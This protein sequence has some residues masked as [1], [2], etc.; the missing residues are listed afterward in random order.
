GNLIRSAA[1]GLKQTLLNSGLLAES[2]TATDFPDACREYIS[3]YGELKFSSCYGGP[4]GFFFVEHQCPCEAYACVALAV[5]GE[6]SSVDLKTG[7]TSVDD[8]VALQEIGK[9]LHPLLAEGQIAGGVAQA[10]GFAL[11]E[12]VVWKDGR[13][14]NNQM[15]NYIMPTSVDLPPIRVFFEELG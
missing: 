11:Y 4:P 14:I 8:F 13:M 6:D 1:L 9:V 7:G 15:T 12:K 2:Y 3:K 10:I 5:D